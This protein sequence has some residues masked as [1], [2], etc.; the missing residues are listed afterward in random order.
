MTLA[1]RR[2]S[3]CSFNRHEVY[4]SF[5]LDHFSRTTLRHWDKEMRQLGAAALRAIV[6][7]DLDILGPK[8][9][10]QLVSPLT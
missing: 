4:R 3:S 10:D 1:Y 9:V 2:F 5:L 8:T 6:D 7:L